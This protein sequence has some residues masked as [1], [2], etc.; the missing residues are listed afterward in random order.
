VSEEKAKVLIVEDSENVRKS[1][2]DLL[3]GA[4]YEVLEAAEGKK[5]LEIIKNQRPDLILLDLLLPEV[6]GFQILTKLKAHQQMRQ[7]PVLVLSAL[8]GKAHIQ[9]ILKSG[10]A[11]YVVKGS[12]SP[13]E[14]LHKIQRFLSSHPSARENGISK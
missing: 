3:S 11:D 4:G 1:Y 12:H 7:I 2:V 14:L 5:A 6:N 9:R 10:V 13:E 8:D